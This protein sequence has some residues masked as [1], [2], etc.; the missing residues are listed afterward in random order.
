MAD[1]LGV[2]SIIGASATFVGT[3]GAIWLQATGR[4]DRK[5]DDDS[6]NDRDPI[7]G[8][9]DDELDE[10]MR[11]RDEQRERE[12]QRREDRRRHITAAIPVFLRRRRNR[13]VTA[14]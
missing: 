2:A 12:R 3:T 1:L 11:R 10:E 5:K 8:L 6:A 7:S 4:A 9:T 13:P 14:P